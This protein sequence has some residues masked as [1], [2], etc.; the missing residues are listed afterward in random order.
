MEENVI[1]TAQPA[2]AEV[3][4][5]VEAAPAAAEQQPAPVREARE[6]RETRERPAKRNYKKQSRKVCIFCQEKAAKIDYKDVAKLRKFIAEGGK[7]LPRRM[8]GTCAKH[9]RELAVAI[10]RA[11]VAS[12]LPFKA[13]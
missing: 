13:D 1:E 9:Q 10:K 8:T 11:R 7:I 3:A 4:A 6:P 12:L 2:E 5:P